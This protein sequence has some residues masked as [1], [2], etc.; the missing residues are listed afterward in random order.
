VGD[1]WLTPWSPL[2]DGE[3]LDAGYGEFLVT[4]A[5]ADELM[6]GGMTHINGAPVRLM[7]V[8]RF[9]AIG[10]VQLRWTPTETLEDIAAEAVAKKGQRA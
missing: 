3:I 8:E 7:I 1:A 9:P 5:F 2:R 6:D 10:A 4:P